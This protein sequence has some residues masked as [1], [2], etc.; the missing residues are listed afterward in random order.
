MGGGTIGKRLTLSSGRTEGITCREN[1]GFGRE[2]GRLKQTKLPLGNAK[3]LH[4][5]DISNVRGEIH[6]KKN[7]KSQVNVL[8][9]YFKRANNGGEKGGGN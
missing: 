9:N 8:I 3:N 1:R 7:E 6:G 5:R 2:G 4:I